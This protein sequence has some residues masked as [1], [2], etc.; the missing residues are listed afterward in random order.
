M[1]LI[2][3]FGAGVLTL[4]NPCILPLLPVVLGAAR[5]ADK[6]GP[7]ALAAGLSVSFVVVGVFVA[8]LG[9]QI[10]L[11]EERIQMVAAVLMLAFGLIL[12]VPVF[13]HGFAL[14]T[15]PL[16]RS[17]DHRINA[18]A[19]SG[20]S[21]QFLTGALLGAVW[22]PCVGPT[23]GS[24]I[25]LAYGGQSLGWAALIML[26]FAIGVSSVMLVLAYASQNMMRKYSKRLRSAGRWGRWLLGLTLVGVALLILSGGL[27]WLESTLLDV[28]PAWLVDFSTIL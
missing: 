22:G 13:G 3:A 11:D 14:A 24:A 25:A 26:A 12:I 8:T 21:A 23:L 20:N 1:E 18:L 7:L 15:A 27:R 10:G 2:F 19:G 16:A 17:A 6:F 5:G 9:Q 4:I 28:M